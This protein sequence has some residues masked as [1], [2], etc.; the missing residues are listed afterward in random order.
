[1]VVYTLVGSLLMLAGA[2]ATGVIAGD[3]GTPVFSMAELAADPLGEGIQR[4][5]LLLLRRAPS[6]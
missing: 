3:G 1:M 4:L 2:I 6:W 5:D